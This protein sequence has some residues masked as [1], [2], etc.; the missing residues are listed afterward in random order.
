MSTPQRIQRRRTAGWKMPEGAVYVGRPTRWGNPFTVMN[1]GRQ[2]WLVWDDRDR[3][4]LSAT[5][6]SDGYVAA[7]PTREKAAADA[8]RRY[9]KWLDYSQARG[10]DLVPLLRGRDL[11][12]WCHESQ[13]CHADV[14]LAIAN[15][16]LADAPDAPVSR[17]VTAANLPST[18][19][20]MTSSA[21]SDGAS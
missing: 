8:V 13:P 9:K 18:A 16:S 4:G 19:S 10:M 2:G 20:P 3:L 17:N 7:F 1:G 11:A 14:L 6:T 21:P 5:P 12:C 15:K